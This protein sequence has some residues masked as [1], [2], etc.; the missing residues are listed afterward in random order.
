[1]IE[2]W[3]SAYQL[4]KYVPRDGTVKHMEMLVDLEYPAEVRVL[5][6]QMRGELT[7]THGKF[8]DVMVGKGHIWGRMRGL[9]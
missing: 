8:R 3:N 1:M 2:K 4:V 6:H 9:E 5:T 7:I